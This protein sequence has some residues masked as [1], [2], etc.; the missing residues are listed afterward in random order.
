M[1]SFSSTCN[2]MHMP[3]SLVV[4]VEA[5]KTLLSLFWCCISILL[6]RLLLVR[7]EFLVER[8]SKMPLGIW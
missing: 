4:V 7:L 2:E 8:W 5:T 3:Y 6:L 1:G